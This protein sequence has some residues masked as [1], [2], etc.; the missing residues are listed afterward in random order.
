M[1][2][3]TGFLMRRLLSGAA[4]V[5]ALATQATLGALQQAPQT[6]QRQIIIAPD[7]FHS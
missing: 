5:F 7:P 3:V 6:T 2:L 4:V 1:K